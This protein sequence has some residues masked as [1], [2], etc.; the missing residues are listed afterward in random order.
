[1]APPSALRS[2]TR[3][4]AILAVGFMPL[5]FV[6]PQR[7]KY[8]GSPLKMKSFPEGPKPKERSE[9]LLSERAAVMP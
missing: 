3:I 2:L 8:E 7:S 9:F 5:Q 1:M 4:V 6:R